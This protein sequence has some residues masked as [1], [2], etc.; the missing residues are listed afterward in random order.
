MALGGKAVMSAGS[1]QS[2]LEQI[3]PHHDERD[4][5]CLANITAGEFGVFSINEFGDSSLIY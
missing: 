4:I 3:W 1:H 5:L 2:M